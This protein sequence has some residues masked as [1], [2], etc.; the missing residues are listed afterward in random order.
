[1]KRAFQ[2]FRG[3]S[4]ILIS[5]P[6]IGTYIPEPIRE[7]MT[8]TALKLADTDWHIEHVY[9]FAHE[10]GCSVLKSTYSRYVIDLNRDPDDTDLYPGQRKTGLVPK[11]DFQD[12]PLYQEGE[13]PCAVEEINRIAAY[14]QPYHEALSH[15]IARIK[16]EF[17]FCILYDAHSIASHLPLI[18]EGELPQ[19]SLGTNHG[20]TL[21]PDLEHILFS[22]LKHTP[23]T[24]ALNERFI[25]GHI[26]RHYGQPDQNVFAVQMEINRNAYMQD[27]TYPYPYVEDE[28]VMLKTVLRQMI[29]DMLHWCR[30]RQRGH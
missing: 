25:G 13:E 27:E 1:M 29:T 20:K 6:H 4:P 19:L 21:P 28:A 30:S 15:E 26:T 22:Q 17:G 7:R 24:S 14:W 9:D 18:Y 5:M 10:M 3:Q 23:F 2:L 11:F 12:N 16:E 8:E